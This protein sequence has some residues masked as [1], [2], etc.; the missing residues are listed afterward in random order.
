MRPN[1]LKGEMA[2]YGVTV[3]RM[4]AE[5]GVTPATVRL[6]LNGKTDFTLT[7][8]RKILAIFR[9]LGRAYTAEELFD[10]AL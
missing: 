3:A 6:K 8:A 5:L 2:R 10:L 4:A 7:E 9:Q 1:T